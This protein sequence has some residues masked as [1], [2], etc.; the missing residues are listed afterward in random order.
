[1]LNFSGVARS[2]SMPM[3]AHPPPKKKG[4]MVVSY[5]AM[6]GY[7]SRKRKCSSSEAGMNFLGNSLTTRYVYSVMVARL[8]SVKKNKN[9]PLLKLLDHLGEELFAAMTTGF[10]VTI[11]G[12]RRRLYL[13]PISFKGDWPALA[14]VASFIRHY[15]R[16]T[17]TKG[18]GPGICHLCCGGQ[19]DQPWHDLSR[20]NMT[21]LREVHPHHGKKYQV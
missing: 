6:L 17:P 10:Q 1:M 14:K 19:K 3:K 9:G 2:I 7:G 15:G 11:D 12:H 8:Y 16:E 21:K 4:L 13:I 18:Y 20:G 5:Q